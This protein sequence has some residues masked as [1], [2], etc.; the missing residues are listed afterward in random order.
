MENVPG[1]GKSWSRETRGEAH[2]VLQVRADVAMDVAGQ[3]GLSD[4]CE[5]EWLGACGLEGEDGGMTICGGRRGQ[6]SAFDFGFKV[7]GRQWSRDDP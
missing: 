3:G 2:G 1:R 7:P 5:S 4:D 6:G